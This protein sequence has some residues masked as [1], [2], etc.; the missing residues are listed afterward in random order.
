MDVRKILGWG[1]LDNFLVG[2]FIIMSKCIGLEV[3]FI[4]VILVILVL[5]LEILL[6]FFERNLVNRRVLSLNLYYLDVIVRL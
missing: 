3:I 6:L 5:V 2:V 1:Y 4:L